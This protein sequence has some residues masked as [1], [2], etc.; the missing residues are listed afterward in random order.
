MSLVTFF[1]TIMNFMFWGVLIGM[2]WAFVK[3]I[4]E[5]R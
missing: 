5:G 1:T 4:L 3:N 2:L